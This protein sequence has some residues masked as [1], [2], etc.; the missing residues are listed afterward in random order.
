MEVKARVTSEGFDITVVFDDGTEISRGMEATATGAVAKQEGSWFDD[1]SN[2][3]AEVLEEL[4][5][6]CFAVMSSLP[7]F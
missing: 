4:A 2:D 3:L 5:D 6:S 1:V 7:P